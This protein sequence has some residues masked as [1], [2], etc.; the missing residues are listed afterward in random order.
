MEQQY[1]KLPDLRAVVVNASALRK[2]EIR[3]TSDWGLENLA[4]YE[5]TTNPHVLNLPLTLSDRL[6]HLQELIFSDDPNLYEFDRKQ[7]QLFCQCMDWSHLR[8][9]GLGISCPQHLF[10]EIGSHLHS[11]RSLEMGMRIGDRRYKHWQQGPSTCDHF[12]PIIDFIESIPSLL[13]LKLTDFIPIANVVAPVVVS[14]HRALRSLSYHA[15][16]NRR[17]IERAPMSAWTVAQLQELREQCCDLIDLEID[18]PLA[19]GK[20]VR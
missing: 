20:W 3:F 11:L 8:R 6:P 10:E 14:C 2:L 15:S 17:Q 1:S 9:L 13:E 19:A 5:K 16:M 12:G 18:F 7:C 4:W